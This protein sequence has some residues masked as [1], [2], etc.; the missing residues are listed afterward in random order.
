MIF[1]HRT[2]Q[3]D[4]IITG[5]A[6]IRDYEGNFSSIAIAQGTTMHIIDITTPEYSITESY[7][8]LTPISVIESAKSD[9]RPVF[10]LLD[11]LN[12]YILELPKIVRHGSLQ[13]PCCTKCNHFIQKTN[14]YSYHYSDDVLYQSST[15]PPNAIQNIKFAESRVLHSSHPHYIAVQVYH[16]IIHVFPIDEQR[17]PYEIHTTEPNI[18]DIAFFGPFTCSTRLAVLSD[19]LMNDNRILSIYSLKDESTHEFTIDDVI[20]LPSDAYHLL[21]L[22]P[23]L[24]SVIN[25]LTNDGIMRITANEGLE[26]TIEH[27]TSY[28]PPIILHTC[29]FYDNIYLLCDSCGGLT[30]ANFPI[31]GP[32]STENMKIVGPSSGI[33]VFDKKRFMVTSP[34]GNSVIYDFSLENNSYNLNPSYTFESSGPIKCLDFRD[35]GLVCGTG[36]DSN[37][38]IRLF[39]KAVSCQKIAE[40]PISNCLSIFVA[41]GPTADS[42]YI[43]MCFF[44]CTYIVIFDGESITPVEWSDSKLPSITTILF[45]DVETGILHLSEE[46]AVVRDRNDGS[47]ISS[48]SFDS[49]VI[50]AS[51]SEHNLITADVDNV[52]F[53]FNSS[54]ISRRKRLT[55]NKKIILISGIDDIIA[56]YLIDNT[57]F[58]YNFTEKKQLSISL[59]YLTAPVSLSLINFD[60]IIAGTETGKLYK[61]TDSLT[62]IYSERVGEGKIIIH[63]FRSK[64]DNK[65]IQF[66]SGDPP[67]Q[68]V[69]DERNFIKACPC[70]DIGRT[71]NFL[72]CLQRRNISI[73]KVD[74]SLVGTTKIKLPKPF[75]L[76]FAYDSDGYAIVH[77][78]SSSFN[79][80][81][82]SHLSTKLKNNNNNT[83][84]EAS[85]SIIKYKR[86]DE[87]ARYDFPENNIKIS[88][89]RLIELKGQNIIVIGDN[90]PSVTL[91]DDS[92]NKMCWL[93]L[94]GTP[95]AATTYFSYLLISREG[96]IDFFET[97][98]LDGQIEMERLLVV[99]AQMMTLDFLVVRKYLVASD[100]LQSLTVYSLNEPDTDDKSS[101]NNIDDNNDNKKKQIDVSI[102]YHDYSKKQLTKLVLFHDFIF[103]ASLNENIFAF[104]MDLDGKLTEVGSFRCDSRV[105]SFAVNE[106][107]LFYGTEGGGIKM[108]ELV[109]DE[110]YIKVRNQMKELKLNF[111]A[112]RIP[113]LPFE[114]DDTNP[115]VDI[116]NLAVLKQIPKKEL[117]KILSKVDVKLEKFNQMIH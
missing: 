108:F 34:F 114:W 20:N 90:I 88:F 55:L 76:S 117:D 7:H 45:D 53:I 82:N 70:E 23:E 25:V 98:F 75:M 107:S 11:N 92:M 111:I 96:S 32:I 14:Q 91:L 41:N 18:V 1:T 5:I 2:L 86:D 31:E 99:D 8:F 63:Q 26:I 16:N 105:L 66:C 54:N 33:L 104:R 27:V 48:Y 73:Y 60:L 101:D 83:T 87:V 4:N 28:M 3:P 10:V 100:A 65:L 56:A 40:I 42:I 12:W 68:L 89:C 13:K 95:Y 93:K 47:I 97:K 116:D 29:H 110:D 78:D 102:V 113:S 36:V 61:I 15:L 6:A 19:S 44:D 94:L 52:I 106:N 69:D 22:H 57:I 103:A 85:Q 115:F 109:V 77:K 39:E 37:S 30:G 43:C 21:P 71:S 64:E 112:N 51:L 46:E 67:F 81:F 58:L 79:S 17:P 59:P 84:T 62:N 72:V 80:N 24:H 49:K 38:S 35:E 9:N 50:S 74:E